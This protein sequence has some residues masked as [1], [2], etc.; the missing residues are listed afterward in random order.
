MG[1][2]QGPAQDRTIAPGL[3]RQIIDSL[4]SGVL[5]LDMDGVVMTANHGACAHLGLDAGALQ[6]G[7]RLD[8]VPNAA[9]FVDVLRHMIVSRE[10][11]TRHEIGLRRPD[12]AR[13]E[14]G[15]SASVLRD[16]RGDVGVV[17]L[18]ADITER[19]RLERTAELNRQLASIGELTAG[20]VHELRSPLSVLSGSA[21]LLLRK[22]D[23]EDAR[24]PLAEGIEREALK[25]EKLIAQFLGFARPFELE[26]AV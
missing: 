1:A 19:R 11:M 14:V 10:S 22:L 2:T 26:I 21:Q 20:V 5:V 9:P 16:A 3:Y 8:G 7:A 13:K 24:R 6:P 18:F 15:L 12:G 4:T 25:L 17:F 23:A